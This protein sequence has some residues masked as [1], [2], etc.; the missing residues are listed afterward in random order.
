MTIFSTIAVHSNTDVW[1]PTG[2]YYDGIGKTKE[3]GLTVNNFS[4]EQNKKHR[5]FGSDKIPLRE[6][7]H[8][9]CTSPIIVHDNY[10]II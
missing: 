9:S 8:P 7:V 10:Y 2:L 3:R 5:D 1:R 4:R 6:H